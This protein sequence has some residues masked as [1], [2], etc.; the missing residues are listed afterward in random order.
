MA[1]YKK[2]CFKLSQYD[3]DI[4]DCE[5]VPFHENLYKMGKKLV[6]NRDFIKNYSNEETNGGYYHLLK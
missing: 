4:E 2:D 6:I 5:H 1:L 3:P